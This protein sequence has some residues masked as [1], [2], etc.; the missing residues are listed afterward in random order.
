MLLRRGG[1]GASAVVPREELGILVVDDEAS[2]LAYAEIAL[3]RAGYR[4]VLAPSGADAVRLSETMPRLDLLV[5][6]VIMPSMNGD[7]LARRLRQRDPDLK[8]LYQT[9]FSDRLFAQKVVLWDGE[10]FIDKPY[11]TGALGQAISLLLFGRVDRPA[12]STTS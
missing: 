4:P 12:P 11:S 5:T 6:D 7:E 9:G 10:A 2:I 1:N 3:A 8:V